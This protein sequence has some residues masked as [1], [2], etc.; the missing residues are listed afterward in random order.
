MVSAADEKAI[1]LIQ[2]VIC[3][4]AIGQTVDRNLAGA[5]A[6]QIVTALR[7]I[8]DKPEPRKRKPAIMAVPSADGEIT[9]T[10]TQPTP[11]G[12]QRPT[13]DKEAAIKGDT[14]D[15]DELV[16]AA[17][18]AEQTDFSGLL[19]GTDDLPEDFDSDDDED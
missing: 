14:V 12:A 9:P 18:E 10:L 3:E 2:G 4:A 17:R 5:L 13:E 7:T 16:E 11:Y 8:K 1:R 6:R 19:S 15:R